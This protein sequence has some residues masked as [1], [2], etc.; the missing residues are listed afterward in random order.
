MRVFMWA[1]RTLPEHE[2]GRRRIRDSAK[3]VRPNVIDRGQARNS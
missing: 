1:L 3:P 2:V